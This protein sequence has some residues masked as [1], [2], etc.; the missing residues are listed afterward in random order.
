MSQLL[1]ELALGLREREVEVAEI[2]ERGG[3]WRAR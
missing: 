2:A 1:D 3:D